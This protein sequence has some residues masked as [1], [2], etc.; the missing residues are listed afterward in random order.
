VAFESGQCLGG[1]SERNELLQYYSDSGYFWFMPVEIIA[2]KT[3]WRLREANVWLVT[4]SGMSY[5]S[6]FVA[7]ATLV[8]CP[9]THL[10]APQC[11]D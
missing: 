10:L 3:V 1:S 9:L 8:L 2:G 5:C 6:N 7:V 4:G 11:G